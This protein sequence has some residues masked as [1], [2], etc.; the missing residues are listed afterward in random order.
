MNQIKLLSTGLCVLVLSGCGLF[1]EKV[2]ET[3][4]T[5][6]TTQTQQQTTPSQETTQPTGQQV[7]PQTNNV[8]TNNNGNTGQQSNNAVTQG[9]GNRPNTQ[10][11]EIKEPITPPTERTIYFDFDKSLVR[12]DMQNILAKHAL[13]LSENPRATIV[14]E[15]HADERGTREYNL[16]LGE[17]RARAV[18]QV[19]ILQGAY[20]DQIEMV[21]YGEEKPVSLSHDDESWALNRRV[22]FVYQGQ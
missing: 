16:A 6:E 4:I 14:L 22:E 12:S 15:G 7:Q 18:K 20:A 11:N 5:E 1:G 13:Y 3:D 10:L 19:L 17:R 2:E 9:L 21:S 8:T